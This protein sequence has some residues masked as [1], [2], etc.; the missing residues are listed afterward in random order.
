[1]D[2][3]YK[4]IID[5]FKDEVFLELYNVIADPEEKVNLVTDPKYEATTKNLIEKSRQYMSNTNDLL[6]LPDN[7]YE[8]FLQHYLLK[9][10][11]S[12]DGD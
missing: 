12:D 10:K 2:G 8:N 7:L 9:N 4:L 5:T 3:D 1:M 11:S 6:K